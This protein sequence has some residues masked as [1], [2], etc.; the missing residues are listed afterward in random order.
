MEHRLVHE[1]LR[2]GRRPLACGAG[3]RTVVLSERGELFACEGRR[4]EPLGNVRETGYDVGA[5]LRS[6]AAR[7]ALAAVAAGG[8][9]CAHECNLLV[10]ACLDPG[11]YPRLLREWARLR[12]GR[13]GAE[14]AA[15][16]A[17]APPVAD[18][19][20]ADRRQFA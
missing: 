5:V 6:E 13:P 1:T 7:R 8:C 3:R 20:R 14:Q 16:G 11:T 2:D 19:S 18:G 4:R 12:L 15:S 10:D 17:A 9:G